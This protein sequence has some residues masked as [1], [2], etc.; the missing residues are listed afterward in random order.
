MK[1]LVALALA[2]FTALTPRDADAQP[3][4][5][6]LVMP[7]ENV[8]RNSRILWLGEAS[9]VLLADDLNALGA[10]A[11]TREE[12]RAAFER[13]QVPPAASLTD[14]T[15]I[16][17]GQL[18]GAS[19]VVVG[20]L[21]LENDTLVVQARSIALDA[22]RL[23]DTVVERGP[24]AELFATMERVARRLAPPSART[25]QDVEVGHPPLAAFEQYVKGLLAA[26]PATAINYLNAALQIAPTFVRPRLALWD[27]YSEQGDHARALAAV[28]PI[29]PEA[30]AAGRARFRAG[31]SQL[32]L[33]RYDDAFATFT[34]LADQ[35]PSAAVFNNLGVV[36]LRR[37]ATP[38]TGEPTYFFN[39]AAE[40]D[41]GEPDYFFNLGY[42]YWI[43]RDTQAAIYWLREAVRR[44]PADGDA[45]Y[46]LGTALS[47]AGNA[48]EAAR[49]KEL[50]RRLSSTY[51]EWD[52]RAAADPIPRQL[53][54]IKNDV[55]LPRGSRA[56]ETLAASGRDQRELARFY[57]ERGR[58]LY[59]QESDR[60]ALAALDRALFLSP[61]QAE[62]HLL[63]GRIHLRGGRLT[64]AADAL[65]ISLWSAETVEAHVVLGEV[66]LEL[67]EPAAARAEAERALALDPSS[68]DAKRLLERAA[69]P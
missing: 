11:I 58:N 23:R 7:F 3:T 35:G 51:A 18:V 43:G 10:D 5:R 49:E 33:A 1:P 13:L 59:E 44:N 26:T 30:P 41:P 48:A 47:A 2:A 19:Q 8:T 36:Q 45:H 55:E 17:L 28:T 21:R 25:T 46:V 34:A 69:S 68:A 6:I 54:R 16:R 31:L 4:S 15:V 37:G 12:R 50:A 42:A 32:N 63:V 29:P 62:A 64:D 65:K 66:H 22:G 24:I 27:V 67:K 60:E 53:E 39:R 56:A 61:Y 9:A 40:G 14:A 20:S 57:L 38:Q 52:Q